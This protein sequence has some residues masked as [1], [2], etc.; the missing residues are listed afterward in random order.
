MVSKEAAVASNFDFYRNTY[1]K[2]RQQQF[3]ESAEFVKTDIQLQ[4]MLA[5]VYQKEIASLEDLLF[6]AGKDDKKKKAEP[7]QLSGRKS[8]SKSE[9][10][11][12]ESQYKMLEL[13]RQANEDMLKRRSNIYSDVQR[14]F[15]PSQPALPEI[16]RQGDA[17][18]VGLAP[19]NMETKA[20]LAAS[21]VAGFTPGTPEAEATATVLFN[22]LRASA[23]ANGLQAEFDA[24]TPQ[25]KAA[26]AG[27][28][29]FAIGSTSIGANLTSAREAEYQRRIDDLGLGNNALAI[30]P[31][32]IGT[33]PGEIT[34]TD[35]EDIAGQVVEQ[36]FYEKQADDTYK[37]VERKK[38]SSFSVPG[39]PI[40]VGGTT[41]TTQDDL[42]LVSPESLPSAVG[43]RNRDGKIDK[44][45]GDLNN[46]GKLDK[47]DVELFADR[48]LIRK[49]T[50]KQRQLEYPLQQLPK[51]RAR[52]DRAMAR[53]DALT[54]QGIESTARARIGRETQV[55]D[56][57][58]LEARRQKQ[59]EAY[60]VISQMED[61]YNQLDDNQRYLFDAYRAGA[62]LKNPNKKL[63][64][65][66]NA[67][68]LY[69]TVKK[70]AKI[71]GNMVVENIKAFNKPD[72][73]ATF[74]GYLFAQEDTPL[75]YGLTEE[76]K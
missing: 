21:N 3:R 50:E 46:D 55:K 66:Q 41:T 58:D 8:G 6:K 16:N 19:A 42:R 13:Q 68:S 63:Q 30:I 25:I 59:R 37:L 2:T 53:L 61:F 54:S 24:R 15:A 39:T 22:T 47:K 45:D 64:S 52:Y 44:S 18:R 10:S 1:L 43:D 29:N 31:Q 11:E 72:E 35:D 75:R 49:E 28:P 62:R 14:E 40:T 32:E 48:M 17:F 51:S 23:A 26:I 69:G 57:F 4:L 56:A 76:K 7:K 60:E 33:E 70:D 27:T 67:Q 5:Q 36:Y 12:F 71:D 65:F 9:V 20:R 38:G 34:G 73:V 74:L